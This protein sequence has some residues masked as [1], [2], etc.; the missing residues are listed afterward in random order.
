M[1]DYAIFDEVPEACRLA[2]RE[3]EVI[4]YRSI[5]DPL[6]GVRPEDVLAVRFRRRLT[7]PC[8]P[9]RVLIVDRR[10]GPP[11]PTDPGKP[12]RWSAGA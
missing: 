5:L 6:P 8:Q 1:T 4:G 11:P 10:P 7:Q 12:T 3:V 9:A 2:L